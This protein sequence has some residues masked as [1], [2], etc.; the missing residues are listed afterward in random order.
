MITGAG[1]SLG[2]ADEVKE[3]GRQTWAFLQDGVEFNLYIMV[4][5]CF[6]L[7]HCFLI[8]WSATLCCDARN[9]RRPLALDLDTPS[10]RLVLALNGFM[11]FDA[12]FLGL[13]LGS[14]FSCFETCAYAVCVALLS[15]L[16]ELLLLECLLSLS[17]EV[18]CVCLR[19]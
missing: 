8:A 16:G 5:G 18:R 4:F 10:D 6:V 19:A 14:F 11:V 2:G 15:G 1:I 17:I 13:P 3:R 7:L 9:R 12:L